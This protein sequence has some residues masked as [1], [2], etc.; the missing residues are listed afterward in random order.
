MTEHVIA[1]R[2]LIR[3]HQVT[4]R[5]EH[6][7]SEVLPFLIPTFPGFRMTRRLVGEVEIDADDRRDYPDSI[8]LISDWR[9]KG[10][11]YCIPLRAIRA[12]RTENLFTAGRCISAVG[13]GWDMTRVIPP[14]AVTGEAAGTACAM[15]A[16]HPEVPLDVAALQERLRAQK[17]LLFLNEVEQP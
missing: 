4:L 1:S 17:N 10:P 9:R 15:I 5:G 16:A 14:C 11:I 6:P 3:E 2:N 12:V 8:G 7:D 13:N